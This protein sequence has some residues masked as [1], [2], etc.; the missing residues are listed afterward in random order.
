M[1]VPFQHHFN[2]RAAHEVWALVV[3]PGVAKGRVY[4]RAIY[5]RAIDQISIA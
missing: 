2:S 3:G 4:D 1:S 5:D